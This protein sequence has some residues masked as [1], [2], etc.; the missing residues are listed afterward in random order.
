MRGDEGEGEGKDENDGLDEQVK[1][2]S[3]LP[4]APSIRCTPS[5]L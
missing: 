5:F 2:L 3:N 1:T 4:S